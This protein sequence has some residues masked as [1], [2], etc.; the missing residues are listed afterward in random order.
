MYTHSHTNKRTHT[1]KHITSPSL[2][3][4]NRVIESCS[5][6]IFCRYMCFCG[7]ATVVI[8]KHIGNSFLGK[9]L[10]ADQSSDSRSLSLS[11]SL[12]LALRLSRSLFL[13]LS[14]TPTY[15]YMCVSL[16]HRQSSDQSSDSWS[17]SLARSLARSLAL[18]PSGSEQERHTYTS[19]I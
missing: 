18:L 17:F 1:H 3:V 11:L 5:L 16:A 6:E 2:N 4:L 9:S 14:L 15:R 10:E 12:S 8:G 13:P 19:R 7:A